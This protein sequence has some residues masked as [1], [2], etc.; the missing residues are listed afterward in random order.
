MFTLYSNGRV[1]WRWNGGQVSESHNIY[2]QSPYSTP[3]THRAHSERIR[4]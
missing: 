3:T 4:K 2:T 1:G